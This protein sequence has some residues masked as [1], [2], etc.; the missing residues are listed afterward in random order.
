MINSSVNLGT[1]GLGEI[2]LEIL[3][4]PFFLFL[5]LFIPLLPAR[6][7]F[8]YLFENRARSSGLIRLRIVTWN[9]RSGYFTRVHARERRGA[10]NI[11]RLFLRHAVMNG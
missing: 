4:V 2:L 10:R 9:R 5:S 11:I 3:V 1:V 7:N 6:A 8:S